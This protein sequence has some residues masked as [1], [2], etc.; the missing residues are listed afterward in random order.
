MLLQNY[1]NRNQRLPFTTILT[2]LQTELKE[3][4]GEGRE[5]AL[6]QFITELERWNWK[7]L[8]PE[9]VEELWDDIILWYDE[10]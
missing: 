1:T 10:G 7:E 6:Y 5:M 3:E 8:S 2:E 4:R 9:G